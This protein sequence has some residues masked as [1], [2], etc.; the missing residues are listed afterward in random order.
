MEAKTLCAQWLSPP[1][2]ALSSTGFRRELMKWDAVRAN[3]G[4]QLDRLVIQMPPATFP[5][6]NAAAE[7]DEEDFPTTIEKCLLGGAR[8][9]GKKP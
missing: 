3:L 9:R 5:E 1:S 7:D 2:A 4:G 6:Y 8:C